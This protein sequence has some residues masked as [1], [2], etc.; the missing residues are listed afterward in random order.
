M[1]VV[2]VGLVFYATFL[3]ALASSLVAYAISLA[4]GVPPTRY[5]VAAP[6]WDLFTAAR[7]AGLGL[8]CALVTLLFCGVMHLAHRLLAKYL[9]NPWLRALAGGA[10]VIALTLLC[11]SMR[12]NG[13]GGDVIAQAVEQ[14]QALPL[15]FLF[16]ILF[17]ALTLGAGYKGGEGRA[18]L[19]CRRNVW[20]RGRAAARPAGRFRRGA[21]AGGRVLRRNQLPGAVHRAGGRAVRRAGAFVLPPSPAASAMLCPVI[22]GCTATRPS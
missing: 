8:A 2:N 11:G 16:K 9:P 12:Y 17:T 5:T 13:A 19:L 21:G 7:T 10:A 14:G 1:M 4:L 3:P 18:Q 20:L 6:G 15:D 22:P